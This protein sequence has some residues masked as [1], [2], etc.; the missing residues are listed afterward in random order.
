MKEGK[1]NANI[2]EVGLHP[3]YAIKCEI[4][5]RYEP[6][7]KTKMTQKNYGS[8][9]SFEHFVRNYQNL[10]DEM[11]HVLS[12]G[13]SVN[14]S[15]RS[16]NVDQESRG[17]P[18]TINE[19]QEPLNDQNSLPSSTHPS[20]FST[21]ASQQSTTTTGLRRGRRPDTPRGNNTHV[22]WTSGHQFQFPPPPIN[23]YYPDCRSRTDQRYPPQVNQPLPRYVPYECN[24]Q[25]YPN[26]PYPGLQQP[27]TTPDSH[28]Q[29]PQQQQYAP[30]P[31]RSHEEIH[32]QQQNTQSHQQ[33]LSNVTPAASANSSA[34]ANNNTFNAENL[35]TMIIND[36]QR[37]DQMMAE[38]IRSLGTNTRDT[39]YNVLPDLSKSIATYDGTGG[40]VV[41]RE[42]LR[43]LSAMKIRQHWTE[44][45][46]LETASMNLTG[47]AR[48]W[49]RMQGDEITTFDQ[50][51]A[52][53]KNTFLFTESAGVIWNDMQKRI[54]GKDEDVTTYFFSKA[55][56][57]E[58]LNLSFADTKEQ[59][60]IGL[61]AKDLYETMS[62]KEHADLTHLYHSIMQDTS[63]REQRM[64]RIKS[65]TDRTGTSST[66]STSKSRATGATPGAQGSKELGTQGARDTR[67]PSSKTT[68]NLP[69]FN[70]EGEPKCYNCNSYGHVSKDCPS[71]A[72]PRHC[73][74]CDKRHLPGD[75]GKVTTTINLV[76][77][78]G[79]NSINKYLKRVKL[80]EVELTGLIDPGSA[81]CTVKAT[82]VLCHGWEMEKDLLTLQSFGPKEYQ[83]SSPGVVTQN[84]TIEGV[85]VERI[86]LRVVPDD[87][88]ATDVL[89]GR[90]FTDHPLIN[91]HKVG[92]HLT[93]ELVNTVLPIE[94]I[95][96][97]P[98]IQTQRVAKE[99]HI[100][101]NL[102]SLVQV[103]SG[104]TER[105]LPVINTNDKPIT[106]PVGKLLSRGK[107][108]APPGPKAKDLWEP[109][110]KEELN[111]GNDMPDDVGEELVNV[112]NQYRDTIAKNIH[113][114]GCTD[115][116]TMDIKEVPG[117]L[118]VS[119]RPY[120]TNDRE[121]ESIRTIVKEWKEAGIVTE[122]NSPYA[123]P[124]LLVKK[125]TGEDRGVVDF[126]PLNLQ[127]ERIQ[128]PLPELDEHLRQIGDAEKF[129][130]LDLAHGY[131]QVPLVPEA[132][133][134]T[135]FITPD[136]TG[137][138]TRMVFGLM[139]APF[140]F[141]KVMQLALGDLRDKVAMFYL[142]DILIPGKSWQDLSERLKLVLEAL[143]R[144]KLTINLKK[145]FFMVDEVEYLG[146]TI[147]KVGI[148][149]GRR[150]AEAVSHY[151]VPNDKHEVRRFHGLASFFRKFIPSFA[152]V[153][154]PLTRLLKKDAIFVW[155]DEQQRAYE[156]LRE[157]I[158]ARP[159]LKPY[160]S[161]RP[162][163]LHTDAS[164][165]GLG[166]MLM[167]RDDH[168]DLRLVYAISRRTTEPERHYHS[169]KMELLAIV[170][171]VSRL[172]PILINVAFKIIS[173][174][175]ALIYLNS[176]KMRNA[177]VAR[178][179]A[180]LNE[181]EY[182]IEHRPGTKMNHVDALSRAPVGLA[183]DESIAEER[184]LGIFSI[185]DEV[186]E[187]LLYQ[188]SDEE[189]RRKAEILKKAE[190]ER[191]KYENGEVQ[192]YELDQGI[193]YK[194]RGEKLLFVIPK[195]MRKGLVVRYHDLQSHQGLE[196]TLTKMGEFYYFPGMK[197]YVRQ[198]I[199]SCIDCLV[200]KSRPGRQPGQL[201]PIPPGN[202]PFATVHIDHVGPY[203]SS[204]RKNKYVLVIVDN[205]TK[206]CV[207][208]A[209]RDTKVSNVL[210]M[211]DEFVLTYGAPERIISDRGTCF[212]AHKFGEFCD[213]HGI[214]HVLNSP[215][216]PRANG[217]VERLN[218]TLTPAIQTN[219]QH[220]D[221]RD[222][223]TRIRQIQ[224]D[225]NESIS[226]TTGKS[227]FQILYGYIPRHDEGMKRLLSHPSTNNYQL[228]QTIQ[229]EV[230]RVIT[231]EQERYKERHDRNRLKGVKYDV[232]EIIYIK[233]PPD[234]TGESTKLQIKTRGPL[235]ITKVMDGD[236]YR[237]ADLNPDKQGRRYAATAHVSQMKV[238]KPHHCDAESETELEQKETPT[239]DEE[240]P[241]DEEVVE[242]MTVPSKPDKE[243]QHL[244]DE[245]NASKENQVQERPR[246]GSR[247]VRHPPQRLGY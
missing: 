113:E 24:Y 47:G 21:Q 122:T 199:Q 183:E 63:T 141:S 187:I 214:R 81:A 49:Y 75:C 71:P 99:V 236:T 176:M 74:S 212:T 189:L 10:A 150:K 107:I 13:Y 98:E 37:R 157:L 11:A 22:V 86:P 44:D 78:K 139:N 110:I 103:I 41:A 215:R 45:I 226:K 210:K 27:Q 14:T 234:L 60:L 246:R 58:R 229:D 196:R 166:A 224:R 136:E 48:D 65:Q 4:E 132:R 112:L 239:E 92:E 117:S 170:W 221:G 30:P 87:S 133:A 17:Q 20:T 64:Q 15:M 153:A 126:R 145:S 3:K 106:L 85:Q 91:Y 190:K 220:E 205:L 245:E 114:I 240:I 163:E 200:T 230:R 222:W 56:K 206:F 67:P 207:L 26:Q 211:M 54:Q 233:K 165:T 34:T 179:Y 137:E 191:T 217:Q 193:L 118:P 203:V 209:V 171:A 175:Q 121:R 173:D 66:G 111:L 172:R 178:W 144:A 124:I 32:T 177:Q 208:K 238:W 123:S 61:R 18:S 151:P 142:D 156:K 125:K 96:N 129:I 12:P 181:F 223:D 140:Y 93:F 83:V 232:G 149:P 105:T 180:T 62:A 216:H 97:D 100:P 147:S 59:I 152:Q 38:L 231:K 19:E 162:T 213:Q 90:P 55:K 72:K 244:S 228:P 225:L 23:Q 182:D 219:L 242:E 159:I 69:S 198:H 160:I 28:H 80:G 194:K 108:T 131:L 8:E 148:Q 36:N 1:V 9:N 204:S 94:C 168:N 46:A 40:A 88:Q 43:T 202:R 39:N 52:A 101:P 76:N 227:P 134:K 84:I 174:C 127:T 130:T 70:E 89:I 186:S 185:T 57:C 120:K 82:V 155:S 104:N 53:F 35:L 192:D 169:S 188:H 128:F 143:R 135:A 116:V 201:H 5:R 164:A 7:L 158:T 73:R 247:R 6:D 154:E 167:Q 218:A 51:V 241:T 33:R 102:I 50:F 109:V 195:P 237:V 29:V 2:S 68:R 31:T 161:S 42:W 184:L 25:Q 197:R 95:C 79:E 243:A 138:F 235:I 146:N 115:L 16:E 77:T 119:R